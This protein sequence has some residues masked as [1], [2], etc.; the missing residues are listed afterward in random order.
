LQ[1]VAE[2]F[3]FIQE[4]RGIDLMNAIAFEVSFAGALGAAV[5][6][7]LTRLPGDLHQLA[8]PVSD[9]TRTALCR[10]AGR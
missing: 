9:D 7:L 2:R 8:D 6:D 4:G 1:G 3:W 5:D 10:R